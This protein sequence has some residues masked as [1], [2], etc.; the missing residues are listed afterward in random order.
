MNLTSTALKFSCPKCGDRIPVKDLEQ[1]FLDEVESFLRVRRK[2]G[3]ELLIG[4][5]S[6]SEQQKLLREAEEKGGR[7]EAEISKAERL[8]LE[9]RI[10]VERFE[11]LYRPLEDE[12]RA[13]QRELGR[14]KAKLS[15]M[16]TKRKAVEERPA[17]FDPDSLRQRWS[18]IVPV[19]QRAIVHK[20]V[21]RI[22]VIDDELEF[23]F[24]F[25]DPSERAAKTQ[26]APRPTSS[27]KATS[28]GQDEPLYVRL[29]KPG[30]LCPR[31]GMTRSALNELILPGERNNYRPPVES[32]SLRKR[33][34]GKGT[35]LIIWQSLKD[36]LSK[37][38]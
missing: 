20:F 37:Q 7:L 33:E 22:V 29:P 5:K 4:D 18:T 28:T 25:R 14:I 16:E 26:H 19:A 12:R 32:K 8:M 23:T 1:R 30:H 17:T 10:P 31:T 38:R 15:R 36:Y 21:Q 3:T 34:G 13:L 6:M 27:R 35:R 24:P 2:L 9:N 11:K